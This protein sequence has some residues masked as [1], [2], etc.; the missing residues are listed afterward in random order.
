MKRSNAMNK[1]N[2][3]VPAGAALTPLGTGATPSGMRVLVATDL[4]KAADEALKQAAALAGTSGALCAIHVLPS[5]QAVSMLFP[6]R[7]AQD[8]LDVVK[9]TAQATEAVRERVRRV[10]EGDAELYVAEGTDYAEIVRHAEAWKADTIVVGSHGHGGLSRVLGG[11]AERVVR[12]AHCRVLVAR[13]AAARGCVVAATDL[14]VPSLPAVVAAAEEAKRRGAL[15]KV[16]HAVDFLH[17]ESF[18][19]LGI[20]TPSTYSPSDLRDPARQRLTDMMKKARIEAANEI[21]DGPAAAAIVRYADEAGA[22]LV[23]V[24]AHG[25]TG[26]TRLLLGS[27]A[28]KIVRSASCSVLVVRMGG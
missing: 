9:I 26:L 27:V 12:H 25:R 22:E 20:A 28:E 21:L 15:L 3:S 8:A 10:C 2:A 11:V 17:V 23:V 13:K 7:H 6:Q 4:S 16:A 19:L 14:S 24:G 1:E 18:Y 5:L